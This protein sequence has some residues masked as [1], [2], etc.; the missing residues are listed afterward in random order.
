MEKLRKNQELLHDSAFLKKLNQN[1]LI[2]IIQ[3]FNP[4]IIIFALAI[5]HLFSTQL[6][7]QQFTDFDLVC[8]FSKKSCEILF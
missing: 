1:I 4:W 6:P 3:E 2:D 5:S 8:V 7:T